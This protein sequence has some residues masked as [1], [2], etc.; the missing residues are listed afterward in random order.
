MRLSEDRIKAAILHPEHLAREAAV[1]YFSESFSRDTE[2]M[3]LAIRAI[4]RYGRDKAFFYI[5][6]IVDLAQTEETIEWVVRELK[7]PAG[8]P[9]YLT[10]LSRLL[11]QA[12]PQLTRHHEAAI[13]QAPGFCAYSARGLQERIQ[14]LSW[15]PE[16]C[17]AELERVAEDSRSKRYI[18]EVDLPHVRRVNEALARQGESFV[19]R[20]LA[21]LAEEITDFRDNPKTWMECFVVELAGHMRLESAIPLIVRKVHEVGDLLSSN[22]EYALARI[23]TDQAV[24]ALAAEFPKAERRFRFHAAGILGRIR[25]DLAVQKC[26]ELLPG[27]EDQTTRTDFALS[28]MQNFSFEGIEPVR[29]M[30]LAKDFDALLADPREDLVKACLV[31][32]TTFPEFPAWLEQVKEDRRGVEERTRAVETPSRTLPQPRPRPAP[33]KLPAPSPSRQPKVG[34]NDPCPCGSGKKFKV[35][36]LRKQ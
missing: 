12:D 3:P 10:H 6:L 20:V 7:H 30:I 29:Q 36:C 9:T 15:T 26:L 34:R 19:D 1:F 14:M 22:C 24:L 32:E 35:C 11:E 2:V 23:G 21:L 28:L 25:T 8:D 17:W 18:N 4:E 16:Q 31:M 5:H 27:E 13:L 33:V